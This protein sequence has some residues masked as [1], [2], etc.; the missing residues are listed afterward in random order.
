MPKLGTAKAGEPHFHSLKIHILS[1][2]HWELTG[3]GGEQRG[4]PSSA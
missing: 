1:D 3:M 4:A 2:G